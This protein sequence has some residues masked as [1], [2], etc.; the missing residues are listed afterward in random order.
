M[1]IKKEISD[2]TPDVIV[3]SLRGLLLV[4]CLAFLVGVTSFTAHLMI[5]RSYKKQN[6]FIFF[7]KLFLALVVLPLY[8]VIY[9][10]KPID[11]VKKL[12]NTGI[13]RLLKGFSIKNFVTK[14]ISLVLVGVIILPIWIGGYAVIGL[15]IKEALGYGTK[16]IN[17][18]GTGS[19]FP[20]FPKGEGKDPEELEKQIVAT[21]EMMPYPNGL[22]IAGKRY[23]NYKIDRG[24][25]VVIENEK[26]K[27]ITE[28]I[29]GTPS[30]WVKRVIGLPGDSIELREGIVYLNDEPLKEPYI[31]QPRSTFGQSF[32]SECNKVIVPEGHIFIMGDNRKAS[33]DSRSIGF[34]ELSAVSHV[35]P[36]KN[37]KG[38]LDKH[39]RDTSK[40]FDKVSK[41]KLDKDKYL[42]FLNEKRREA[43]AKPLK[44]QIKLELSAEKRGEVVLKFD[45]FSTMATKSGYTM[46]KAMIDANYSNVVWGEILKE[47]YYESEE[48]INYQFQLPEP[49]EFI[50]DKTY[51]EIGIAEVEGEINGCPTRVIVQHFAG[52]VPPN[53]EREEIQRWKNILSKLKEIQPSWAKAKEDKEFYERNKQDVDRINDIIAIRIANI[54]A[55]VSRMEA[56]QWFTAAELKVIEQD[57][58][59]HNEQKIIANRLINNYEHQ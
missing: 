53:Y 28:K 25:I 18:S 21:S 40:D 55:I 2:T 19:M 54:P 59:L 9:I 4:G 58:S 31:A 6:I 50:T 30:A 57:E 7:I 42:D 10:L 35:I 33:V 1:G 29:Y 17:I 26:I 5:K 3:F 34:I 23:F 22:V 41:I 11:F 14:T 52:Y 56:N 46:E 13:Q 45:D 37:Q 47:G 8:L 16:T 43:G 32:L 48:F 12:K 44:Y 39:W 51:Q 49:K 24:D 20:T 15:K 27:E 36:F 38:S